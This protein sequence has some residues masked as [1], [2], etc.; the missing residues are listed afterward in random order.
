MRSVVWYDDLE[1]FTKPVVSIRILGERHCRRSYFCATAHTYTGNFSSFA[2]ITPF[3]RSGFVFPAL[4]R[5]WNARCIWTFPCAP[6]MRSFEKHLN[7]TCASIRASPAGVRIMNTSLYPISY[8][9]QEGCMCKS[10]RW[11]PNT[12]LQ[13]DKKDIKR[14]SSSN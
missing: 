9:L 5:M 2:A 3:I 14:C 11:V 4:G 12:F 8:Q 6:C 7:S 1:P 13:K 10:I